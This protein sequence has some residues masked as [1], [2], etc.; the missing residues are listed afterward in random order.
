MAEKR[1]TPHEPEE[2]LLGPEELEHDVAVLQRALRQR[3][4]EVLAQ[5]LANDPKVN[6]ILD[7][8]VRAGVCKDE[9]EAIVR[10]LETFFVAVAPVSEREKVLAASAAKEARPAPAREG[11]S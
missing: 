10:A 11:V 3:R 8:L 5:T 6:A 2:E 1:F 7:W 9:G 4:G